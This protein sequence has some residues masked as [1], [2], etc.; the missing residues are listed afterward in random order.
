MKKLILSTI[1]CTFYGS[2]TFALD[3]DS[4]DK[5][6]E[7]IDQQ[8]NV[9]NYGGIYGGIGVGGSFLKN[10]AES[11]NIENNRSNRLMGTVV[12]GSGKA[13]NKIYI[14]GELIADISGNNSKEFRQSGKPLQ[15]YKWKNSGFTPG[16]AVRLGG[17]SDIYGHNCLAYIK[18]GADFPKVTVVNIKTGEEK[19]ITN[20]VASLFGGVEGAFLKDRLITRV[21]GGY[22]FNQKSNFNFNGTWVDVKTNEG[23]I[24]RLLVKCNVPFGIP[25]FKD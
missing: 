15:N 12:L 5:N 25:F 19:K 10:K 4:I 9:K 2:T 14:G 24:V 11:Q 22:R 16:V 7:V 23:L 6:N 1:F 8:S 20:G 17:V 13:F 21:E 3:I 18:L